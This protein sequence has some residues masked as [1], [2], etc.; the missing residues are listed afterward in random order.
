MSLCV[1]VLHGTAGQG[2]FGR[3]HGICM[4]TYPRSTYATVSG[5][6]EFQRTERDVC[7]VT[8]TDDVL[9]TFPYLTYHSSWNET[10]TILGRRS[11]S[12]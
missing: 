6:E 12:K 8:E 2:R 10:V 9:L 5:F 3:V 4:K 11:A 1:R 7:R